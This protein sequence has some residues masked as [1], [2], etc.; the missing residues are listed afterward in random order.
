[1]QKIMK[2]LTSF[3]T[4][5]ALF[6]LQL[7]P[8]A[9]AATT[10]PLTFAQKEAR[11]KAAVGMLTGV[12]ISSE[13]MRMTLAVGG[14]S[15]E[16]IGAFMKAASVTQAK[17]YTIVNSEILVNGR[18][19][20]LKVVSYAPFSLKFKGDVWTYDSTKTSSENFTA[21]RKIIATEHA[22][23]FSRFLATPAYAVEV[24]SDAAQDAAMWAVPAGMLAFGLITAP[25]WLTVLGVAA[26]VGGIG[27]AVYY[28]YSN[29]H[30]EMRGN[31]D[32]MLAE[33]FA[34]TC[35]DKLVQV[36]IGQEDKGKAAIQGRTGTKVRLSLDK[37]DKAK[38]KLQLLTKE[39]AIHYDPS[40][41][42]PEQRDKIAALMD[43]KSD[44]DAA[45]IAAKWNESA[46]VAKASHGGK[47]AG[48][49]EAPSDTENGDIKRVD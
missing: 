29:D 49:L 45:A 10:L 3:L 12:P 33:K 2:N 8:L 46:K 27:G 35:N 25:A 17:T 36:N 44:A 41:L 42:T 23:L 28:Y 7:A 31:F 24:D 14:A 26:V 47:P 4:I 1:M 22:S 19:S 16:D 5:F 9:E 21:I 34:I 20:G 30:K 43:C 37:S 15:A 18:A 48:T 32:T 39:G 40:N 11:A 6:S 38:P 13:Q